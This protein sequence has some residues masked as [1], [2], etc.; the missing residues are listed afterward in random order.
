MATDA[1]KTFVQ[2]P[3]HATAVCPAHSTSR[4]SKGAKVS[5]EMWFLWDLV[6]KPLTNKAT[7]TTSAT[8]APS[9]LR[10]DNVP[11]VL[12]SPRSPLSWTFLD[13]Y[14]PMN[15]AVVSHG[16]AAVVVAQGV[17]VV[18]HGVVVVA[19]GV[20][21]VAH[22]VVVVQVQVGAAPALLVQVQSP[23]PPLL[24][25]HS[26]MSAQVGAAPSLFVQE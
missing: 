13:A 21:V 25:A 24:V 5:A 11:P 17:V 7:K 8:D 6:R 1:Q 20:V 23:Q 15:P 19:H 9:Q 3:S 4:G 16:P 10:P 26:S 2:A 12:I 14:F 22:G 18:A